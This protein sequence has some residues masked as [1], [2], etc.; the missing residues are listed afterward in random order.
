VTQ[1]DFKRDM[2]A[3]SLVAVVARSEADV[4]VLAR[5]GEWQKLNAGFA[6]LDRRFL[7]WAC[8]HVADVSGEIVPPA[9]SDS[10]MRI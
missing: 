3:S 9:A 7:Q 10:R 5:T 1:K 2:Y 6:P 4:A 8:R